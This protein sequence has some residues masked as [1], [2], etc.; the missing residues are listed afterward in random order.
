MVLKVLVLVGLLIAHSHA[1]THKTYETLLNN[2]LDKALQHKYAILLTDLLFPGFKIRK[3]G[4]GTLA[5]IDE[6]T[7]KI[8]SGN[9]GISDIPDTTEVANEQ[10]SMPQEVVDT[11][12][13]DPQVVQMAAETMEDRVKNIWK[14]INNRG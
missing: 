10:I 13:L 5:K 9:D 2:Q 11:P 8:I 6:P 7:F 3:G 1:M 12:M 14:I 4:Y